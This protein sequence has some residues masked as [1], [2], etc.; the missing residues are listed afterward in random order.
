M[1]IRDSLQLGHDLFPRSVRLRQIG[2]L[3]AGQHRRIAQTDAAL[4]KGVTKL[5][6][7]KEFA[8]STGLGLVGH[9][10]DIY[11]RNGRLLGTPAESVTERSLTVMDAG[12]LEARCAEDVYKRQVCF[13][14]H[15]NEYPYT[16]FMHY[17]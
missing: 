8:V 14:G 13:L 3:V 17:K 5:E 16:L 15:P 6:G 1:C 10:V 12:R 11:L 7:H 2:A 9:R 4:K